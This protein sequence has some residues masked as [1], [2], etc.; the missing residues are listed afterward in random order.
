METFLAVSNPVIQ[1]SPPLFITRQNYKNVQFFK[2]RE[3]LY[4]FHKKIRG[5]IYRVLNKKFPLDKKFKCMS[6]KWP[7][8]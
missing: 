5:C 3:F 2:I 4:K 6:K 8:T 1:S 7:L